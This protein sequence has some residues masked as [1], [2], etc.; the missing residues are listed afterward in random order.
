[1]AIP[2]AFDHTLGEIDDLASSVMLELRTMRH[3]AK[4]DRPKMRAVLRHRLRAYVDQ[5]M[6]AADG[7]EA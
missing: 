5:V 1:M 4:G 2:T 7:I 3:A 6:A